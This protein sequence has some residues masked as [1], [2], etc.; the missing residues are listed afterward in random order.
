MKIIYS[1]VG[2]GCLALTLG[3]PHLNAQNVGIGTVSPLAK[4]TVIG[5]LAVGDNSFNV[6][7]PSSTSSS[8]PNWTVNEAIFQG[9]VG[10]GTTNPTQ[11][12]R[13]CVLNDQGNNGSQDDIALVSFNNTTGPGPA[14]TFYAGRGTAASPASLQNGDIPGDIDFFGYTTTWATLAQIANTFTGTTSAPSD[15]MHIWAGGTAP[16]AISVSTNRIRGHR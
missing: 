3:A 5:S 8:N 14:H 6:N 1:L 15:T 9:A 2:A 7:L 13:F 16:R 11:Y 12:G 10:V 4:L